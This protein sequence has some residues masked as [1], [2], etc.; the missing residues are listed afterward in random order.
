M[1]KFTGFGEIFRHEG[2]NGA[3]IRLGKRRLIRA[4]VRQLYEDSGSDRPF[5]EWLW[6]NREQIVKFILSIIALI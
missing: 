4:R 2:L 5:L 6:E 1:E 3:R